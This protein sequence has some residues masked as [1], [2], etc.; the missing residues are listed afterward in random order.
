[1]SRLQS[2]VTRR[3]PDFRLETYFSRW[4]FAA[5]YHL[6][7][8]DAQTLTIAELLALGSDEERE[9]FAALPLGYTPTWGTGPAAGQRSP[10]PTTRAPRTTCWPS[11][12]PRRRS[13]G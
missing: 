12:V 13:T 4:E 9:A 10:R 11:P 2:D 7:A 8:S 5:K 6:T 1:M 3:L